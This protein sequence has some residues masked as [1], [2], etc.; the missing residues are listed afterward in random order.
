[1]IT[2]DQVKELR[3]RTGLGVVQCKNALLESSG[4]IEKAIE[5]L[6][7]QGA[8][9]AAKKAGRDLGAGIVQAYIHG[10]GRVGAMVELL[11]ETDFVAKNDEFRALAYELAMQISATDDT[12][13]EVG[14][15]EVLKQ[16]YIKNPALSVGDLITSAVQK[17]GERTEICRIAKFKV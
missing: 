8:A 11:C 9:I 13:I 17:F 5:L 12:V 4:D 7:K 2:A 10:G 3:S 1:M 6:K 14:V 16:P 15:E